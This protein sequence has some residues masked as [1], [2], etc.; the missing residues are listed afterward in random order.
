MHFYPNIFRRVQE[1][2]N[3][4]QA[5][6]LKLWADILIKEK[7]IPSINID[8]MKAVVST[9]DGYQQKLNEFLTR[10]M[11]RGN[12]NTLDE[13]IILE[14]LTLFHVTNI[15]QLIKVYPNIGSLDR[16]ILGII[17][18]FTL[19]K[20]VSKYS[21]IPQSSNHD[22]ALNFLELTCDVI[23]KTP[24]PPVMAY[25]S[26]ELLNECV[27]SMGRFP[28]TDEFMKFKSEKMA[29]HSS[30]TFVPLDD[31]F[32]EPGSPDSAAGHVTAEGGKR[33]YKKTKKGK[34]IRKKIRKGR[35]THYLRRK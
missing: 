16:I 26:S 10:C 33:K 6:I 30:P 3:R 21:G 14:W 1:K 13:S 18:Q 24:Q 15:E 34:T 12:W 8:K 7:K 23:Q 20:N 31:K 25:L 4:Y 35:R 29:E 9:K 28:K 32:W 17:S 22:S 11:T 19:E 2:I 27:K 5:D